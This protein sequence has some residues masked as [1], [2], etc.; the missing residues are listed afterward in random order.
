GTKVSTMNRL[1]GLDNDYGG[2]FV[3]PD[4]NFTSDGWFKLNFTLYELYGGLGAAQLLAAV[5][6]EPFQVFS[7]RT[8]PG[9]D[10]PTALHRMF[11]D[12]GIKFRA[13]KE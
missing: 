10:P 5:S 4:I 3:F 2:Y 7:P 6:S 12:Q 11:S 1:R 13:R 9:M 8:F